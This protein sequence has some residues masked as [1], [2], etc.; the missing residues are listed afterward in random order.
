MRSLYYYCLMVRWHWICPI[1]VN[2]WKLV[3][4]L[5]AHPDCMW[6]S[7]FLTSGGFNSESLEMFDSN[8]QPLPIMSL[9]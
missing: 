6:V 2:V 5:L 7:S 4:L 1:L 8:Y 9:V 3:P